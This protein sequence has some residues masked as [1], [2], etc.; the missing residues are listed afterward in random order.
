MELS[1]DGGEGRR[2]DDFNEWVGGCCG[3]GRGEEGEEGGGGV[4]GDVEEGLWVGFSNL[5][6][7]RWR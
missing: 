2:C 7:F 3:E 1:V 6:D 5:L 4:L